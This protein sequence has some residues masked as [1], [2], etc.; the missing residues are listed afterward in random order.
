MDVDNNM[1]AN[2]GQEV[3]YTCGGCGTQQP[4]KPQDPVRCRHCAYRILYKVRTKKRK[5]SALRPIPVPCIPTNIT[6]SC[7]PHPPYPHPP[8]RSCRLLVL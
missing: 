4:L 5:C 8:T 7:L 6:A 1:A 3:E 2:A